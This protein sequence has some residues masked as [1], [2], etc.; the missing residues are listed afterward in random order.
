[1]ILAVLIHWS[2][3][4]PFKSYVHSCPSGTSD[5]HSTIDATDITSNSPDSGNLFL[6]HLYLIILVLVPVIQIL[7]T[8]TLGT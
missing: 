1:M 4:E 7:C 6:T 2:D 8:E 5:H 3:R